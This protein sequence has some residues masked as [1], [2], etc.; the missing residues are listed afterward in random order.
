MYFSNSFSRTHS[1]GRCFTLTRR[2]NVAVLV[3]LRLFAASLHLTALICVADASAEF[4]RVSS[5]GT[6]QG[7]SN[8]KIPKDSLILCLALSFILLFFNLWGIISGRTLRFGFMNF[9]HVCTHTS[10]AIL[11]GLAWYTS[12]HTK[13]LWHVFY[14]LSLSPA[15]LEVF[16]LFLSY[17]RGLDVYS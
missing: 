3:P 13:Q 6:E 1:P 9:M 11:L 5:S 4:M 17:Y 2:F 7:G 12:A 16:A 10:A 8:G 15:L 14:A